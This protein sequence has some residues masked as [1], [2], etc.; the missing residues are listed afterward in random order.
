MDI[1]ICEGGAVVQDVFGFTGG[2]FLDLVVKV[3]GFPLGENGR[4]PLGE[5]RFHRKVGFREL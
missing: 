2:S 4:L 1:A 3:L 5:A